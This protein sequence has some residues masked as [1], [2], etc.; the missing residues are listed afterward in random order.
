MESLRGRVFKEGLL[1]LPELE[2]RAQL[3]I[4]KCW[5][6]V[7]LALLLKSEGRVPNKASTARRASEEAKLWFR[8]K[9]QKTKALAYQHNK[10]VPVR[11]THRKAKQTTVSFLVS[12]LSF[13]LACIPAVNDG[14]LREVG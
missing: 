3:I 1:T 13:C 6:L 14:V 8:R 4:G 2:K 7:F 5:K 12:R 10:R 11:I 9:Q